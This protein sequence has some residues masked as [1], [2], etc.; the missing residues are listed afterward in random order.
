MTYDFTD[1]RLFRPRA[2]LYALAFEEAGNALAWQ[3]RILTDL[4][5]RGAGLA[6]TATVTTTIFGGPLGVAEGSVRYVALAAFVGVSACALGLLWSRHF[7][8]AL[9]ART[10]L[11][12]YVEPSNVPL[13][14]VHRDLALV[15]TDLLDRNRRRLDQMT[16]LLR[17]GLCLLAV[18]VVAWVVSY[19]DSL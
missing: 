10:V 5:A 12:D 19:A 16:W 2:A 15:R 18:E 13:P 17:L 11:T 14:L 9:D 3:E 4:R 6:G 8:I 7:E 1:P